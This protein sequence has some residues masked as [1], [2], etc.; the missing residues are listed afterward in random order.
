MMRHKKF[1]RQHNLV[2]LFWDG[3]Q[4]PWVPA[5]EN[6]ALT[7]P[8]TQVFSGGYSQELGWT[9]NAKDKPQP[10]PVLQNSHGTDAYLQSYTSRYV[11]TTGHLF[12]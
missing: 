11:I 7:N 5:T 6:L 3:L 10:L 2:K 4:Q 9:V 8:V 12:N 1:Q